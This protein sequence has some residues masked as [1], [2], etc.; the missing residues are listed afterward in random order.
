MLKKEYSSSFI[1]YTVGKNIPFQRPFSAIRNIK[2]NNIKSNNTSTN[3]PS[4]ILL[5]DQNNNNFGNTN[6]YID[7]ER[8][9]EDNILLKKDINKIKRE[10]A[11]TKFEVVKKGMELK[12]KEKII[13]DCLKENNI[14]IDHQNKLGKAKESAIISLYKEKYI[15]LKNKY[16]EKCSENKLLKSNIKLTKLEE[17]KIENDILN[18]ELSKIKLLYEERKRKIEILKKNIQDF[19]ELKKKFFEQHLIINSL[20][21]KNKLLNEEI[22][23]LKIMN[24]ELSQEYEKSRKKREKLKLSNDKLKIKNIKFLNSKKIREI[25]EVKII[26]NEYIIKK[27]KKELND[28]KLAYTRKN[29]DYIKL[30]NDYNNFKEKFVNNNNKALSPFKYDEISELEKEKKPNSKIELYKS[31]YDDC[32]IKIIIYEKYLQKNN[33]NPNNIIKDYGYEGIITNENNKFLLIYNKNNSSPQLIHNELDKND[34]KNEIKEKIDNYNK[35]KDIINDKIIKKEEDDIKKNKDS[36]SNNTNKEENEHDNESEEKK[37]EIYKEEVYKYK[38]YPLIHV[39]LK[40]FEAKKLTIKLVEDKLKGIEKLFE[41]KEELNKDEFLSPFINLFIEL[42]KVCQENDKQIIESF[43]N[44][45]IDYFD[46]NTLDFFKNL[47]KIFENL[48]DYST[49]ENN[50]DILNSLAYDLQKYKTNL[51]NKLTQED[52]NNSDNKSIIK[53][54]LIGYDDFKNIVNDLNISLNNKLMEFLLYKMKKDT[55]EEN[56]IFELNYGI[57]LNLLERKIP[58]EFYKNKVNEEVNIKLS[59]FK[60][61]MEKQKTNLSKVFGD[62]VKKLNIGQNNVEVIEKDVFF[63]MMGKYGVEVRD[64]IKEVIYNVFLNEDP[65][66]TNKGKVQMMDFSKIN[67]LFINNVYNS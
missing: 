46:G 49:L 28:I 44:D 15:N 51:E 47:K 7:K 37:E 22:E 9:Y 53:M 18:K 34:E 12:E 39:F 11:E 61:N 24:K 30:K 48:N 3:Y 6:Y 43:F 17:Y 26:N 13:I 33:V 27:L 35:K 56:S 21:Q 55:P 25:S 63:E 16:N 64:N 62:K 8:L 14:E 58:D 38:L 50:E 36:F 2:K 29:M 67:N 10:L 1:N 57:I 60:I 19:E 20:E 32:K 66:C 41:G 59:E 54:N 5:T 40:N 23:N 45:Y 65:Q 52:H 42:M 31:L 4:P